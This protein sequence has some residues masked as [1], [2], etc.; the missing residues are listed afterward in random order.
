MRGIDVHTHALHPKIADKV[1]AQLQGHYGITPVG[2]GLVEDLLQRERAAGIGH[3]IVLCAATAPPQVIPANNWVISLQEKH[4]EVRG[5]GTL[6]P[7]YDNWEQELERLHAAGI[8]G[9]KFH[10]EFQNFRLDAPELLPI[11]EAAQERFAF[12][13][14]V[15]DRLPPEQNPSCPYKLARIVEQFPRARIVAAHLG[16]YLHW[17]AAL[18]ALIGKEVYIDTSSSVPFLDDATLQRIWRTHPRE[19]VLFGSDYPLFD[20]GQTLAELRSRLRLSDREV[21]ELLDNGLGFMDGC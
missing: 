14:H 10:P 2:T 12:M 5:F 4:P 16:G 6:H 13:I 18:E 17:P 21:E 3:V 9:L 1:L 11:I 19:Y 15:G 8:R 7:A 20:P